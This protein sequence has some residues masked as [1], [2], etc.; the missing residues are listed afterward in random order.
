MKYDPI[1]NKLFVQNRKHLAKRMKPRSVAVIRSNDIMPTNAD[2]IMPYK[3]NAN[4][5]YLS[6]VAQEGTILL[7]APD[8]PDEKMR[9][10]CSRR[11][12]PK[13]RTRGPACRLA[14]LL[15]LIVFG[16]SGA[17]SLLGVDYQTELHRFSREK[18]HAIHRR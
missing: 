2:G 11:C 13:V 5:F 4:L 18:Q 17:T 7:L 9:E 16:A 8:F 10:I 12:Q 1:D 6:G 15:C 3:Q 14:G